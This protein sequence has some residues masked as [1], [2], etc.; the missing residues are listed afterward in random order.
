MRALSWKQTVLLGLVTLLAAAGGISGLFLVGDRRGHWGESFY[1]TVGFPRIQGVEI[2]TR[3]RVLGVDAGEV[4]AV[5][6][7]VTPG[8][9][10]VVRLR[11]ASR[12]A[13]L[14]RTD[15]TVEIA[16]EGVIG[17]K[18]LEIQPGTKG[19]A[20]VE[21]GALLTARATPD[22]N[23]VLGQ[24]QATLGAI[25]DGNGTLGKLISDRTLILAGFRGQSEHCRPR[26]NKAFDFQENASSAR[27]V[28]DRCVI[29]AAQRRPH[30]QVSRPTI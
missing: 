16:N 9:A 8:D 14:I 7:P 29:G 23:D 30:R 28:E 25:K 17:G 26:C 18:V 21:N 6:P 4:A 10:V 13:K 27:H 22:L 3:V 11:I 1:L 15:A 5:E 12:L 19:A 24:V 20:A 2:G